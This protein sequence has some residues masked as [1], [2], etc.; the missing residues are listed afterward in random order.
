MK[1]QIQTN[2]DQNILISMNRSIS[3][4]SE[5]SIVFSD[6]DVANE[7][8]EEEKVAQFEVDSVLGNTSL[9]KIYLHTFRCK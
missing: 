6:C 7:G 8:E 2:H 4:K 5:D 1:S 9:S 3:N